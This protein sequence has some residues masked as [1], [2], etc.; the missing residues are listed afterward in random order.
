MVQQN[1]TADGQLVFSPTTTL[2]GG[3]TRVKNLGVQKLELQK[4]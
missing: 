1:S 2:N 3:A 4:L